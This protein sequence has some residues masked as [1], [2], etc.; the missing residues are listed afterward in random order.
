M[1]RRKALERQP[2]DEWNSFT[3]SLKERNERLL[4]QARELRKQ[5]KAIE[6]RLHALER[7]NKSNEARPL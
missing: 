1:S 5:L 4:G 3:A 2:T 7:R 6:E